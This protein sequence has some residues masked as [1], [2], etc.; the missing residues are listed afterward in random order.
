[1][2]IN[3]ILNELR[4]DVVK[5]VLMILLS[6]ATVAFL[7]ITLQE[8]NSGNRIRIFLVYWPSL[9]IIF[10]ITY[11]RIVSASVRSAALVFLF[12]MV[13]MSELISFG[14]ASLTF[15]FFV[16]GVS[17]AGVLFSRKAGYLLMAA[18][19]VSIGITA[20][21][22]VSGRIPILNNQQPVSTDPVGWVSS[23][24][25]Y[26]VACTSLM[27]TVTIMLKELGK[28]SAKIRLLN[29]E[30]EAQIEQR[31]QEIARAV[32]E[33][34]RNSALVSIQTMFPKLFHQ[35]NTPIGNALTA[36]SYLNDNNSEDDNG[37]KLLR[38]TLESLGQARIE[39]GKLRSLSDFMNS[40]AYVSSVD[41]C[42]FIRENRSIIGAD[43][44]AEVNLIFEIEHFDTELEPL[45]LIEVLNFLVQNSCDH[46]NGSTPKVFITFR[47]DDGDGI[48]VLVSDDGPGVLK[49]DVDLIFEPFYSRAGV[50]RMGLGLT[51]ARSIT[52]N[53]LGGTLELVK[54]PSGSGAEFL[55]HLPLDNQAHFSPSSKAV[56]QEHGETQGKH[57]DD[58]NYPH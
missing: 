45:A 14:L 29:R 20:F 46:G 56:S 50:G 48:E 23:T 51:I 39:I 53:R 7:I 52:E 54:N 24:V 55:I 22:Y 10:F 15:M 8:W 4:R 5:R 11:V 44:S 32:E 25:A 1:V 2:S 49:E 36:A 33:S 58:E 6:V 37:K 30:L 57:K 38:I 28:H 27:E 12:I 17:L 41:F 42:A 21:L 26:I 47:A 13:A 19:L 31:N 16:A 35:L 43:T 9:L 3:P 40:G 18:S 34:S